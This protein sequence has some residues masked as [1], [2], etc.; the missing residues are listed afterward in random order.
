MRTVNLTVIGGSNTLM[1]P[2]YFPQFLAKAEQRGTNINLVAN[3]AIGG[4]TSAAGLY[5]LKTTDALEQSDILLIATTIND[6]WIYGNERKPFRHWARLYE[7]IVRYALMRNP[8]LIIC[9]VILGTNNGTY[10]EAVPSIEAGIYYMS[11]WYGVDVVDVD[12]QLLQRHGRAVLLDPG[13]YLDEG[14]YARP[15]ATSMVAEIVT[16]EVLAAVDRGPRQMP[17]PVAID[18]KNFSTVSTVSAGTLRDISGVDL[19]QYKSRL[20]DGEA[21][22]LGERELSFRIEGGRLQG[23]MYAC[24]PATGIVTVTHNEKVINAAQQKSG[25]QSGQ[26]R[27]LVS[28]M[29]SDFIYTDILNEDQDGDYALRLHRGPAPADYRIPA[30][31]QPHRGEDAGNSFAILGIM[32]SGTLHDL[33]VRDLQVA[34]GEDAARVGSMNQAVQKTVTPAVSAAQLSTSPSR[35][36]SPSISAS[37]ARRP[38]QGQ[39]ADAGRFPGQL[40]GALLGQRHANVMQ[41]PPMLVT[42]VLV[43]DPPAS[44]WHAAL[45]WLES[46][47]T[48]PA[49]VLEWLRAPKLPRSRRS[50]RSSARLSPPA[51]RASN[52]TAIEAARMRDINAELHHRFTVAES[53]LL[54]TGAMPIDLSFAN[55]PVTDPAHH[56]SI[57]ETEPVSRKFCRGQRRRQRHRYSLR[58]RHEAGHAALVAELASLEDGRLLERWLIPPA[59]SFRAGRSSV[60]RARCLAKA[61]RSNCVSAARAVMSACQPFR[62]AQ[63]SP[64]PPSRSATSPPARPH[65]ATALPCK[66]GAAFPARICRV[67]STSTNP[68]AARRHPAASSIS[69]SRPWRWRRSST[70]IPKPCA[71]TFRPSSAHRASGPSCAMPRPPA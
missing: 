51:H 29:L 3:L 48:S 71:L 27:F 14:H 41:T 69:R 44:G 28:M 46:S 65:C 55:D 68:S 8:K 57:G 4:T 38:P 32:Y 10:L 36:S 11:S 45:A 7:G 66:S 49:L 35:L 17:L 33:A 60:S 42:A 53:A 22:E 64:F 9:S 6:N 37:D 56:V 52:Q 34:A 39:V 15:I 30:S 47:R 67:G 12:R 61:A 21:F 62:W 1:N 5:Q 50:I 20:F 24:A 18:A 31:C 13:F 23:I 40:P 19:V 54:R 70:S 16:D 25:V 43:S 26:F 59:R 2:G 58:R 63:G